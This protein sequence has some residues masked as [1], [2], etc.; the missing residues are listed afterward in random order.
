MPPAPQRARNVRIVLHFYGF[1]DGAWPTLE[2]T[3]VAFGLG[4]RERVRQ[5][6]S[7]A[8]AELAG[9]AQLPALRAASRLIRSRPLLTDKELAATLAERT[10][11]SAEI[12]V[13]GFLSLLHDLGLARG[14][15]AYDHNL[16]RLT[17]SQ[18]AANRAFVLV[19]KDTLASL[20]WG[21]I[22]ARRLSLRLGLVG[23]RRLGEA[24]GPDAPIGALKSLMMTDPACC[25]WFHDDAFWCALETPENV[26]V[27]LTAKAFAAAR[28]VTPARLANAL[29]NALNAR[30]GRERHAG[31][32]ELEAW[33]SRSRWFRRAGDRLVFLGQPGELTPAERELVDYLAARGEADYPAIKAHMRTRGL[34]TSA[35]AKTATQSPVVHVD[36][37]GGMRSYRYSLIGP[38]ETSR[39][40]GIDDSGAP[41]P[42]SLH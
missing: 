27:G 42:R 41:A 2:E 28:D 23:A 37:T 16:E 6:V 15:E 5:I 14:Y 35:I 18:L 13:R 36:R 22:A 1:G 10:G 33:I 19:R 4:T 31:H 8:L 26:L 11:T 40:D 25:A 7:E 12:G 21:L 17:R 3:A 20:Q 9:A 30:V 34:Q 24:L 32:A 38:V 39:H 29:S